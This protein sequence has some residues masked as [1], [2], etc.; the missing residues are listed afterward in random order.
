MVPASQGRSLRYIT[1]SSMQRN[2]SKRFVATNVEAG[3]A[4]STGVESV[5]TLGEEEVLLV[6]SLEIKALAKHFQ[7]L[8]PA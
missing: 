4:S 6:I 5:Q 3:V 1:P 2:W 7:I 8:H